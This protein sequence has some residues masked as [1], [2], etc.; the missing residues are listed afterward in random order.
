MAARGAGAAAGDFPAFL[1]IATELLNAKPTTELEV[2]S[3]LPCF[4]RETARSWRGIVGFTHLA[5]KGRMTVTIGRRELLVALGCAAAA[6]PLAARAQNAKKI[7][8]KS[9]ARRDWA[10]VG[11]SM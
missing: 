4:E 7:P 10:S 1:A 11:Y 6:W 9:I 2:P 5:R 3:I 8:R